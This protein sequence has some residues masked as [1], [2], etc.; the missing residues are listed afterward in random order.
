MASSSSNQ[1]SSTE[2]PAYSAAE[3]ADAVNYWCEQHDVSPR[4]EQIASRISVRNIHYYRSVGLISA[5]SRGRGKG[6]SEKHFLQLIAIR[7]LQSQ[8]L[9]QRRIKELLQGRTLAD[10]REIQ[11]RGINE[12]VKAISSGVNPSPTGWKRP[13]GNLK[14]PESSSWAQLFN[15]HAQSK[16]RSSRVKLPSP[17]SWHM[18]PVND[19]YLIVSRNGNPV[20]AEKLRNIREILSAREN[21]RI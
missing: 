12:Q 5:P 1:R 4:S 15:S 19:D 17:E 9:P 14:Q 20:D 7:L 3:L 18:T 11:A 10:L 21:T 2:E 13:F 6:F 16:I 8:D